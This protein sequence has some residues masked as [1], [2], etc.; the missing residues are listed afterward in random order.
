MFGN[1]SL[2]RYRFTVIFTRQPIWG[3]FIELKM[4][5]PSSSSLACPVIW[6]RR[7]SWWSSSS[8]LP[9]LLRCPLSAPPLSYLSYTHLSTVGLAA[10]FF[11]SL[12]CPHLAFFSLCAPL[13]SSPHGRKYHLSRFSVFFL[14]ACTTPDLIPPCHS[15]HPSQH[16]HLFLLVLLFVILLL[17]NI[18]W[19]H[20]RTMILTRR[21]GIHDCPPLF[22]Y[23]H[24]IPLLCEV[25]AR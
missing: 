2:F 5:F 11:F 12:V 14:D 6:G 8:M 10:L 1:R 25:N 17:L 9:C 24:F 4:F 7:Y 21:K 15:A 22:R 20:V 18:R 19:T 23:L 16:T 3:L 13:S